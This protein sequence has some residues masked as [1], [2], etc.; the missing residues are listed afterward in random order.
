[1][2]NL[3]KKLNINQIGGNPAV[4]AG[5]FFGLAIIGTLIWYF[6]FRKK[7]GGSV[8]ESAKTNNKNIKS[9]DK[10]N[11]SEKN[12]SND[13]NESSTG[14]KEVNTVNNVNDA[15]KNTTVDKKDESKKE[16][17]SNTNNTTNVKGDKKAA[18]AKLASLGLGQYR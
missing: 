12:V 1:M 9:Q 4:I 11:I 13:V 15:K 6:V 5:V 16:N 2:F 7:T 14:S 17:V 3:K 18:D 10:K 8:S